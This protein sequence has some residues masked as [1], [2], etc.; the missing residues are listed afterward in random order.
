M[1][2]IASMSQAIATSF[3]PERLQKILQT[4]V[5]IPEKIDLPPGK[6]E[7]KFA[8]R[9]NLSGLGTISVP[10]ELK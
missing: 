1:Q 8:V 2:S 5:G 6:Y 10:L 4:G 3:S 9:D 7:V